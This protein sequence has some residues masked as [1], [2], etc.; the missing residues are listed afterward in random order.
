MH[1]FGGTM[2]GMKVPFNKAFFH[3][4]EFSYIEQAWQKQHLSADGDFTRLCEEWLCLRTRSCLAILMSSC[5]DGLELASI[6]AGLKPGD[7]VIMP[8]YT[9]VSTANAIALR[10]AVPVFV[11]IRP[12]TLNIDENKIEAAITGKTRAIVPVH[13]AGVACEMDA[14]MAVAK[15]HDLMVIED[16]AQALGAFYRGKPLGSIGQ[17]AVFSFHETKNISSGEGGALVVNEGWLMEKAEIS[18]QKGTDRKRFLKGQVDK[19]TWQ[20][21]GSSFMPSELIAAY[22]WGQLENADSILSRRL[23]I[24]RQYDRYFIDAKFKGLFETPKIPG[25]CTTNG[26]IYYLT[27]KNEVERDGLLNFLNSEGVQALFHYIPL[28]LSAGGRRYGRAASALPVT[29]DRAG[30]ILRLPLWV[31]MKKDEI[32]YVCDK[33]ADYFMARV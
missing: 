16:A 32:D 28:H 6:L 24:W 3:G 4:N 33:V 17:M 18:S 12:D 31:G 1:F 7:E 26:H 21:L 9:F 23:E 14:V 25:H 10:G 22:L 8:S 5:T 2:G 11:D 15:K 27:V 13:Y 29:E 19:Y 20:E 30:R